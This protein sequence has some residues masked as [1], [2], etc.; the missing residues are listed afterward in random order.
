MSP[1]S[2]V[3]QAS[4]PKDLVQEK[5]EVASQ[6][7]SRLPDETPYEEGTAPNPPVTYIPKKRPSTESAFE[8][9][10]AK[11]KK[12]KQKGRKDFA[13]HEAKQLPDVQYYFENGLRKVRPYEFEYRTYVKGRWLGRPIIET[14]AQE[15]QDKPREYYE[16]AIELGRIRIN[17][18]IVTGAYCPR[19]GDVLTHV[20]HRHEPP[21]TADPLQIVFKDENVLVVNKP[22]SIPIHPTGRYH[23]NTMLHILRSPEFGFSDL[24]PANRLDRLTSGLCLVGRNRESTANLAKEF[25]DRTVEKTYLCRVRGDGETT[26]EEPILTISVKLGVNVVSPEGK[27]CRSV[28]KKQSYNGL[29]SVVECKPYSGRTHQLRVHLQWLGHPIANDPIYGSEIAWGPEVGK[30]GLASGSIS[31]VLA[32]LTPT[33]EQRSVASEPAAP[34]DPPVPV[35]NDI[36][37]FPDCEECTIR[38]V[39]PLPEQLTI[40]LHSWRYAFSEGEGSSYETPV[41]SWAEEGFEGD[42]VLVERFWKH[43]GR[44]DGR[45]VGSILEVRGT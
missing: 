29:T 30:G 26:C 17:E 31:D 24:S 41:P 43:G 11:F 2:G 12:L 42:K 6:E 18:N 22:S 3:D 10:P 8:Q 34:A 44:W 1:N 36:M 25:Q 13:N 23:H 33:D 15:F 5:R 14:F 21:V 40:W 35:T 7:T 39:D 9:P 19:S 16:K 20:M 28:F 4:S 37:P 45:G 27:P 38:R 32:K